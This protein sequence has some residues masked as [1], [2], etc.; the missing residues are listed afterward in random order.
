MLALRRNWWI[1]ITVLYARAGFVA[2]D[3]IT[4]VSWDC[5]RRSLPLSI[6][7]CVDGVV[8]HYERGGGWSG[9]TVGRDQG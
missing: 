7:V 2:T 6:T 4:G 3:V 9:T 1:V 5:M 8:I